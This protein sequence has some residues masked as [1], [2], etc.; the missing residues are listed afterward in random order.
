MH[1]IILAVEFF[2]EGFQNVVFEKTHARLIDGKV[3]A[4]DVEAGV[5]PICSR[6][7]RQIG[8]DIVEPDPSVTVRGT[9]LF[10]W[11]S[12]RELTQFQSQCPQLGALC[13]LGF[14]DQAG[15]P[16]IISSRDRAVCS[17]WPRL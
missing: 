9:L 10:V 1:Q 6:S 11:Y 16:D 3:I 13:L 4:G 7:G 14:G 12:R 2:G 8:G 15:S 5:L 17:T